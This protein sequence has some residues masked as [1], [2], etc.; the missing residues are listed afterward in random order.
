M[1]CRPHALI[2]GD[3]RDVLHVH[4]L[5]IIT[6]CAYAQGRVKCLSPSICL[7]VCL[8]VVKKHGCL[9]SYR[10]KIATK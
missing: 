2:L 5:L 1:Q 10:S 7:F 6:R 3:A 8:F 9:L 4:V